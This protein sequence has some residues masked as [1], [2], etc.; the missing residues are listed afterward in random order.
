[1]KYKVGQFLFLTNLQAKT[2]LDTEGQVK[3]LIEVKMDHILRVHII[4]PNAGEMITEGVLVLEY[5][6]SAKDITCMT[7]AHISCSF[8]ASS[9]CPDQDLPFPQPTLS[10]VFHKATLQVSSRNAI[11]F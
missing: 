11:H 5:S 2:N 8:L 9:S 10:E 1:I 3:F 7:H 4:S 6:V